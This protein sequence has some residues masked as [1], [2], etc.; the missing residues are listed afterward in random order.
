MKLLISFIMFLTF[1]SASISA[2]KYDNVEDGDDIKIII[3][4]QDVSR[5]AVSG[6]GRLK[7]IWS[8]EG[9]L[10]L[11]ADKAN[12]EAF[13]K[14]VESAPGTFSFFA[15]DNY[16]NTYTIIA[17]QKNV[18]SQTIILSPKSKK[19]QE[20]VHNKF[21]MLPEKILINDL[22]KSMFNNKSKDGFNVYEENLDVDIWKETKIKLVK[23]Y[24]GAS[25]IGEIYEITNISDKELEFHES[26]FFG[27]GENV[28]AAGLEN[29]KIAPMLKTRL[30]VVRKGG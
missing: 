20:V 2:Q 18:P 29:L 26:E 3:S 25:Y 10:E 4:K 23:R 28:R 5:L 16:G 11:E 24:V 15:R 9:F 17:T 1:S 12:G 13:F 7:K 6:K 19:E 14:A 21:K 22:F 27:F 30:F 8:P